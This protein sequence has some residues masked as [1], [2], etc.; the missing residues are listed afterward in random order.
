MIRNPSFFYLAVAAAMALVLR[1]HIVTIEDLIGIPGAIGPYIPNPR[2][3]LAC[4]ILFVIISLISFESLFQKLDLK[5]AP[6]N[7]LEKE[8]I[9]V[10]ELELQ[11]GPLADTGRVRTRV[12][13]FLERIG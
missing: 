1:Q 7:S 8:N 3:F 2:F 9:P 5:A 6:K 12:Q 13:A 4:V 10:I 11:Y